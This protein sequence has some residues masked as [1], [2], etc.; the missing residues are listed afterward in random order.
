M[1]VEES[2]GIP[3]QNESNSEFPSSAHP[4]SLTSELCMCR[5]E[6]SGSTELKK[7]KKSKQKGV[8]AQEI[9]L[10]VQAKS[11][12]FTTKTKETTHQ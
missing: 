4:I 11:K 5:T 6:V 10:A 7:K 8:T 1:N 9:K 3:E 2:R 12:I